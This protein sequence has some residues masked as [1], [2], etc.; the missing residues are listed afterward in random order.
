MFRVLDPPDFKF[1]A[2][3]LSIALVFSPSSI[4]EGGLGAMLYPKTS[5]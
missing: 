4:K 2:P 3:L 1:L 5:F